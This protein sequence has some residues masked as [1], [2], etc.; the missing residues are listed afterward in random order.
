MAQLKIIQGDITKI[1]V[2]AIVNAANSALAG[3]GGVDG[4][5]HMAAGLEQL[6]QACRKLHGCPTGQAKVTSGFRL[7]AK[8]II[9]TVGPIWHGGQQNEAKLLQACYQNSLKQ[10]IAYHCHTVAFPSIST[11][12]YHYPL[13]AAVKIAVRTIKAFPTN[14]SVFMVCFDPETYQAYCQEKA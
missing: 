8:Y 7:P 4:A 1:K 11:G 2:D 14:L 9:H 10:A 13:K 12:V 6:N 3:G 5:I